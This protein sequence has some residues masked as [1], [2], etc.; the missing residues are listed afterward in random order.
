LKAAHRFDSALEM[1]HRLLTI[2]AKDTVRMGYGE[3][4]HVP[5][6]QVPE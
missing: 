5:A 6:W 4:P 2:T 1:V 3:F